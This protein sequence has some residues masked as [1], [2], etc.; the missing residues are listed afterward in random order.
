M[1]DLATKNFQYFLS[2]GYYLRDWEM[3]SLRTASIVN[4]MRAQ[5]SHTSLRKKP[6]VIFT[7]SKYSSH[8]FVIMLPHILMRLSS[9]AFVVQICIISHGA[10]IVA[11]INGM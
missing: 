6:F 11:R 2:W 4:A 3:G 7:S 10:M 1:S 5:N 9:G 8:R